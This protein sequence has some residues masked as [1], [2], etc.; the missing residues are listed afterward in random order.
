M[1]D[2]QKIDRVCAGFIRLVLAGLAC[3]IGLVLAAVPIMLAL[4][5]L[6]AP[7]PAP[8]EMVRASRHF[9]LWFLPVALIWLVACLIGT[10]ALVWFIYRKRSP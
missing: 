10:G 4:N 8:D 2:A 3:L 9:G 7:E 1:I 5:A 6:I